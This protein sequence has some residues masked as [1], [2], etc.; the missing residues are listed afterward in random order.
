MREESYTF[1]SIKI[2]FITLE[3]FINFNIKQIQLS[4]SPS[5]DTHPNAVGD[6]EIVYMQAYPNTFDI[7][8]K[9]GARLFYEG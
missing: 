1:F 7:Y 9:E 6:S 5:P 8:L 3:H 2:K 4:L